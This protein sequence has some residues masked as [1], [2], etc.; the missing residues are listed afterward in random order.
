[1]SSHPIGEYARLEVY[2]C[3]AIVHLVTILMQCANPSWLLPGN[4][5]GVLR[6]KR[7]I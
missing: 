7:R 6:H 4:C 2:F 1:M 5:V 3:L